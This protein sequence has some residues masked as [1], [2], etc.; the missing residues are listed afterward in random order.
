MEPPDLY[1]LAL[2]LIEPMSSYRFMR[3][4]FGRAPDDLDEE[5]LVAA[6]VDLAMALARGHGLA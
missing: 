2:V 4:T 3:E 1:A 6:V 5:R